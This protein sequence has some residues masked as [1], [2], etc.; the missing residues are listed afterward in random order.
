MSKDQ[1]LRDLDN[2]YGKF[3]DLLDSI[4]ESRMETPGVAGHWSVKDV[5]AHITSWRRRTVQRLQAARTGAVVP[6][7][8]WP[9]DILEDDDINAWLYERERGKSTREVL[10]DS[11]QVFQQLR[12]AIAALPEADLEAPDHFPWLGGLPLTAATIFSHFHEEHEADM[13]AFLERQG[14]D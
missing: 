1:L 7:P 2:E 12:A 14:A 13:R 9:A 11:R 5:V 4:G 3:E 8:P 6:P 10:D